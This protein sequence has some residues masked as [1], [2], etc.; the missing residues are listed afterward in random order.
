VNLEKAGL[1]GRWKP[2][3]APLLKGLFTSIWG[4]WA[5]TNYFHWLIDCLPQ[6][7]RLNEIH[8]SSPITLLMPESMPAAWEDSLACC[9][10]D[11]LEVQRAS[12]W[13]RPER[14][15]LISPN[16]PGWGAWLATPERE[17]VRTR[18]FE[19]FGL[20]AERRPMR[21]I[22]VSRSRA[23]VRRLINE[24]EVTG[25]LAGYGFETVHL[26]RLSFEQQVRLFHDAAIVA[27]VHGAAFANLLFAG[28]AKVLELFA[29]DEFKPLYFFLSSSLG[30]H[31]QFLL[32]SRGNRLEDFSIDL[33][34][35]QGTVE[36][37]LNGD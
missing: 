19:R 32:G 18:V 15:V 21:R 14:F 5:H 28:R 22:F 11:G 7:A 13:V 10:P 27:G 16:H 35:L 29:G 36:S 3:N 23:A 34:E 12:G 6:L 17:F 8:G 37:M 31:H 33:T 4:K 26:E 9:L 24:D 2:R 1:Y 25:A 20:D 30:L